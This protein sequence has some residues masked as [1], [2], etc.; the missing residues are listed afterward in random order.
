V[1]AIFHGFRLLFEYYLVFRV[2]KD[3]TIEFV[4]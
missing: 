2:L 4:N 3:P 1:A